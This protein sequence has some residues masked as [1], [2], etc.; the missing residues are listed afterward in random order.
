MNKLHV[1][2]EIE[3][4]KAEGVKCPRCWKL[5]GIPTNYQG[6]CDECQQTLKEI[7]P[8]LAEQG[9]FTQEQVAEALEKIQQC[10]RNQL[11][12]FVA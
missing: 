11:R 5:R 8:D 1:D 2:Y 12:Q 10:E 3:V 9:I 4:Q 6:I 7:L